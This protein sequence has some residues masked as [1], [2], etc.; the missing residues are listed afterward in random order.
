MHEGTSD[1]SIIFHPGAKVR[2]CHSSA[3][4]AFQTVNASP[5]ARFRDGKIEMIAEH[6]RPRQD[7]EPVIMNKFE[8]KVALIKFHPGFDPIIIDTLIDAGFRGI[9]FEGTGLGHVSERLYDAIGHAGK[10]GR[11]HGYDEPVHL[12]TCQHERLQHGA[13]AHPPRRRA[14][15]GHAPRDRLRQDDVEPR[16]HRH[17]RRGEEAPQDERRGGV[18]PPDPVREEG[19]VMDYKKIGLKVGIEVHQ[20][21]ATEHKLFCSCPPRLSES[22]PEFKFLRRLRPSQSELGEFDPAALFEFLK[23]KTIQYEGDSATTCLVEMDEEPPGPLDPET[24]ELTLSFCPHGGEQASG[25]GPRY[26]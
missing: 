8:K 23:G 15:R 16:Q 9:V 14:T 1:D 12:G 3:R 17:L 20:E 25:R 24:L 10:A 11:A 19:E 2:K 18:Q 6:Y 26:A 13:G 22:E 5:I 7:S 4:Y 21:L